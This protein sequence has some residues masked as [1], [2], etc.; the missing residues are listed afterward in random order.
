LQLEISS[1]KRNYKNLQEENTDLQNALQQE[2]NMTSSLRIEIT[3]LNLTI[4][5][6]LTTNNEL[7]RLREEMMG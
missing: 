6:N 7:T 1:L 3:E 5:N 4:Q 2:K